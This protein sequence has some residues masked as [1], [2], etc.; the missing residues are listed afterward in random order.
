MTSVPEIQP[1]EACVT[2]E[3]PTWTDLRDVSLQRPCG[4]T[5]L[6][7]L[8][9]K[10]LPL[11]QINLRLMKR[12]RPHLFV[13]HNCGGF[14]YAFLSKVALITAVQLRCRWNVNGTLSTRAVLIGW[15]RAK[16]QSASFPDDSNNKP[17]RKPLKGTNEQMVLVLRWWEINPPAS[18]AAGG[19]CMCWMSHYESTC[20]AT[21]VKTIFNLTLGS[22]CLPLFTS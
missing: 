12:Q 14:N 11:C 16:R 4:L 20:V 2:S 21:R 17:K 5:I 3:E 22:L 19:G 9:S 15:H 18:I 10:M 7:R 13:F 8:L 6:P 1:P